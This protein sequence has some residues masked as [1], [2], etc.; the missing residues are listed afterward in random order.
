[1][2]YEHLLLLHSE[3]TVG[4][5]YL[6]QKAMNEQYLYVKVMPLMSD[7]S[8]IEDSGCVCGLSHAII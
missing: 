8:G 2:G 7:C 1:M 3:T 5:E 4:L 6:L